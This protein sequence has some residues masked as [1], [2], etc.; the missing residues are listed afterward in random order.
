MNPFK[1]K[2]KLTSIFI[3]AGYPS[4]NSLPEQ[5]LS[6]QAQG[7]DFIEV[8]IPF[9]DPMADGTIIQESSSIAI[10]NGISLDLIFDQISTVSP[11]IKVPLVLMGYFN[12]A[13]QYGLDHFM[14]KCE[15]LNI[16]GLI[17][18]DLSFELLHTKYKHLLNYNCPFI[19]LITPTTSNDRI[20]TIAKESKNSFI[21]L[22]S[23]SSTTGSN[24][25]IG[26]DSSRITEIKQL[27]DGTPLMIGF[28]INSKAKLEEVHQLVDGGIIG[29]AYIQAIQKNNSYAFIRELVN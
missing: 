25:N 21:Y 15:M 14:K 18:P 8:G 4:L 10:K 6:L 5:L 23:S 29:S 16:S 12:S 22:V 27:C 17:F 11:E 28:G 20:T 2:H 26:L 7:I 1:Q 24:Q 3:T 13:L 9:S 19:S